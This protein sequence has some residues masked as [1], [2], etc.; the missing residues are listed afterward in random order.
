MG[1]LL[2][3]VKGVNAGAEIALAEG[4]VTFGS[5][6]TCDIVLTDA[7]LAAEAFVLETAAGAVTLK[8]L[9]DGEA[10]LLTPYV[11]FA[12]GGMEFAIG[13]EDSGW[14][15]LKREEAEAPE[16]AAADASAESAP[17]PEA[18]PA[19]TPAG[20]ETDEKRR[21]GG[22]LWVALTALLAAVA[23][24]LG[25]FFAREIRTAVADAKAEFGM[26]AA[27]KPTAEALAA[28]AATNRLERLTALAAAANV[29]LATGA[30]GELVLRGDFARSAERHEFERAV[31]ALDP[32]LKLD[33]ADDETMKA[34]AEELLFVLTEG[35]VTVE[36]VTNRTLTLA[37]R[38]KTRAQL[39]T[40]VAAL[41]A[42]L[43]RV[44][45][46]DDTR[47]KCDDGELSR[48]PTAYRAV[49]DAA[50]AANPFLPPVRKGVAAPKCPVAGVIV[51]PYPCLVLRDG[52]RLAPGATIG[53][54]TVVAI[55]ES[56]VT[57]RQGETELKWKP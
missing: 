20:E 48:A 4:A 9:P 1:N 6:T 32:A 46:I 51:T 28:A 7:T 52:S 19:G 12:V 38:L 31:Y 8:V 27:E 42:D 11:I 24:F 18:P 43:N 14:P 15:E 22:C 50:Q 53:E 5:G 26:T 39:L 30:D 17:A 40:T 13:P 2:K 44:R 49:S 36:A 21:R 47:V 34:G 56:E 25:L 54:W 45:T 37:G 10:K 55:T 35:Q 33:L 57:L 23:F 29:E 3:I 41:C 16:A